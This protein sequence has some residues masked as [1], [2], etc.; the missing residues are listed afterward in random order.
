M[1]KKLINVGIITVRNEAEDIRGWAKEMLYFCK[2]VICVIDP[3]TT[4]F[5]EQI[6]RNEFPQIIIEYQDRSLGDSDEDHQ[7]RDRKLICHANFEKYLKKYVSVGEWFMEM[8]PDERLDPN[9]FKLIETDL[10][11]AIDHDYEGLVFPNY[12]T[13][14]NDL[15]TII[16]WYA[17][18]LY[19]QL[20]QSKFR[21]LKENYSKG[22]KPH[23]SSI[24][25]PEKRYDTLAGFYHFCWVK[26]TRPPFGGWRDIQEYNTFKTKK[27]KCPFKDWKNMPELNNY[28]E[29]I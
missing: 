18:F 8:A 14:K 29:L 11:Y 15:E 20:N 21:V 23:S 6:L 1:R 13:F 16:D 17:H 5:T 24:G 4:D 10:K 26:D 19:G 22:L 25:F 2:K 12:Y 9:E 7:G 3:E 28:G 27:H